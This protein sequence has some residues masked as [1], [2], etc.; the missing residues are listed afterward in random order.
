MQ[1]TQ[2]LTDSY[3]FKVTIKMQ[4]IQ[5]NKMSYTKMGFKQWL[6]Q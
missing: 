4:L 2:T 1:S 3:T 5:M 6:F